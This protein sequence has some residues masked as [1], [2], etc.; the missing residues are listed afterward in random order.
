MHAGLRPS[1]R[2]AAQSAEDQ[3]WTRDDFLRSEADFGSIVVHGHSARP[4]PVERANRFGI[5]TLAYRSGRLTALVLEGT[6]RRY[7][8]TADGAGRGWY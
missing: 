5:D 4:D 1:V 3:M 7:M 2:L 8:D 6:A